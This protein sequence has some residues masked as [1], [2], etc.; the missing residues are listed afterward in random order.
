MNEIDCI[1]YFD[2]ESMIKELSKYMLT[3]EIVLHHNTEDVINHETV[4]RPNDIEIATTNNCHVEKEQKNTGFYPKIEDT[5]FWC[6]F[7]HKFSK[8]EFLEIESK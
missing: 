4:S 3:T 8:T 2:A 5:L 6:I 1:T 7:I